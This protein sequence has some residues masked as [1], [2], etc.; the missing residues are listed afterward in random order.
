MLAERQTDLNL[1]N[2]QPLG[3]AGP[4]C[5]AGGVLGFNGIAGHV[6]VTHRL[7]S[8]PTSRRLRDSQGCAATFEVGF[9]GEGRSSGPPLLPIPR[10]EGTGSA[11]VTVSRVTRDR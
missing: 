6:P 1:G 5:E 4:L 8:R 3:D 9:A 11:A 10:G 2:P 7:G